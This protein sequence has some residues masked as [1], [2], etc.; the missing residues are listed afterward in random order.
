M[1]TITKLAATGARIVRPPV[2]GHLEEAQGTQSLRQRALGKRAQHLIRQP[3]FVAAKAISSSAAGDAVAISG[4]FPRCS[5]ARSIG[6]PAQRRPLSGGLIS[7]VRTSFPAMPVCRARLT[8]SGRAAR[9]VLH[10]L[11][12]CGSPV[13]RFT[14][15]PWQQMILQCCFDSTPI[16]PIISWHEHYERHHPP[17]CVLSRRAS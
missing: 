8:N 3:T 5:E 9:N 11:D 2:R 12:E 16:H 6:S 13:V 15:R 14:R 17:G 7:A 10:R 1:P 4:T